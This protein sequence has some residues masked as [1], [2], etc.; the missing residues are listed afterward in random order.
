M[1][2]VSPR[3]MR[4]PA[5]IVLSDLDAHLVQS[6]KRLR[7]SLSAAVQRWWPKTVITFV[8]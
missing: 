6:G 3:G 7:F 2:H 8:S 5:F 1:H 4:E